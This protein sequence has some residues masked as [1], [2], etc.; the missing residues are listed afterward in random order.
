MAQ[1]SLNLSPKISILSRF[2]A[3]LLRLP[4]GNLWILQDSLTLSFRQVVA[5]VVVVEAASR[6]RRKEHNGIQSNFSTLQLLLLL[7][8]LSR[9][10]NARILLLLLLVSQL[11]TG[12]TSRHFLSLT[13]SLASFTLYLKVGIDF[14]FDQTEQT[15]CNSSAGLIN[16]SLASLCNVGG[17]GIGSNHHD[18]GDQSGPKDSSFEVRKLAH[19]PTNQLLMRAR[20]LAMCVCV[21]EPA[22]T[23]AAEIDTNNHQLAS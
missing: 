6:S 12:T 8:V 7:L 1:C 2:L 15:E 4:R 11:Q 3:T 5:V 20:S 22:A 19:T 13:R 9:Q 14:C 21:R 23:A 10:I 18:D 17:S 16:L